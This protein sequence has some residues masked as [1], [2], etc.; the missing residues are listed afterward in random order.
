M[1]REPLAPLQSRWSRINGLKIYDRFDTSAGT[2]APA[3]VHIHGFGISGTYLEPTAVKLAEETRTFIPDLPG[4]GQSQRPKKP[5]D[6]AGSAASIIAYCDKVGV[7]RATF[8]GNSLG[9]V[10][11]IELAISY[12]ERVDGIV[13]VSPAGGPNNQPLPRAL[14]QI[15][16]DGVREPF[17]MSRVATRDYLRFGVIQSLSLFR[18]MTE[19][20]TLEQLELLDAPTLVI[21]GRRD[22]LVDNDRIQQLFGARSKMAVVETEGAHALNFTHPHLVAPLVRSFVKSESLDGWDGADESVSVLLDRR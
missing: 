17:S 22:P 19:Y 8:V 10:A 1:A 3:V 5:L 14:K 20:P 13:L 12:P 15:A 4:T 7:D 9:C 11:L 18:A 2:D 16:V 21:V 6:I